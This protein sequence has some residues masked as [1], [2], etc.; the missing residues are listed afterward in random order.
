MPIREYK[1]RAY[2]P[3]AGR[4]RDATDR[5]YKLADSDTS[6]E[7]DSG[8]HTRDLDPELENAMSEASTDEFADWMIQVMQRG[9]AIPNW[10]WPCG[11]LAQALSADDPAR[12]SVLQRIV[13]A[14]AFQWG[15]MEFAKL[16]TDR[17]VHNGVDRG[18]QEYICVKVT[19]K[20]GVGTK[21]FRLQ[22]IEVSK[23][24]GRAGIVYFFKTMFGLVLNIISC[25]FCHVVPNW[26][27]AFKRG[28][29]DYDD[30]EGELKSGDLM[31]FCG[32][33]Q[34]RALGTSYW[35][36]AG[37]VFR[38]H[39]GEQGP[40]GLLYIFEANTG[41]PGWGHSD[42]RLCREKIL[43]YKDG[44]VDV[45]WRPLVG[46]SDQQRERIGAA[47]ARHR[48]ALYDH[49]LARMVLGALD[50][51]PC[52]EEADDAGRVEMFCS[53]IVA[54]VWQDMGVLPGPPE[55][56]PSGEYLPRDFDTV[57]GFNVE[58]ELCDEFLGERVM[59]RRWN[60]DSWVII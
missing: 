28:R 41:R 2:N 3:S 36:H 45:A 57:P 13:E 52:L 10:V 1:Q 16:H 34:F 42:L 30:I 44:T 54:A 19:K 11:L 56:P 43:T 12:W 35:S 17:F 9:K 50:C 49:S 8:V 59:L 31:L 55:G 47:V 46:V 33:A 40:P 26:C 38:D 58:H 27:F 22:E 7:S 4:F 25:C 15:W 6:D 18:D 20:S 5:K 23:A 39:Y 14:E 37:V 51:C 29:T 24:Q 53:Q 21:E 32:S 48:G 60:E